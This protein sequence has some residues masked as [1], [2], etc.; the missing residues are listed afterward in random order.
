MHERLSF[1]ENE[2][3]GIYLILTINFINF[4]IT[5]YPINIEEFVYD[6]I[7]DQSNLSFI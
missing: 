5:I 3:Y 2:G 6:N 4:N 1:K 7:I